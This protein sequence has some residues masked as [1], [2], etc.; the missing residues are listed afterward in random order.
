MDMTTRPDA[1]TV[2]SA[3]VSDRFP[4]A[5]QAWLGGS[6]VMGCATETSDLD[7]TVLDENASAHRESLRYQ[8]WPVELFVHTTSSI[9]FFVDKDLA[10][11]KPTMARLIA[12]G[13]PLVA[14][15]GGATIRRHCES[16]LTAGPGSLAPEA[17]DAARYALSDLLDDLR[18]GATGPVGAAVVIET[19]RRT[20]DLILGAHGCWTGGGKWLMRELLHLDESSGTT[21][22]TML[23]EAL[24]SALAGNAQPL[25]TVAEAALSLLGGRLW[26]GFSQAGP[27]EA[28]IGE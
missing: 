9:R 27:I 2:A 18:G 11:R 25:Q 21:W 19:W 12:D 13:V 15:Q 20:A 24:R 26:E 8:G 1:V 28:G 23:D 22:T 5:E 3:L 4:N 7:I 6:V 14:G 17:I 10:Q 16:V